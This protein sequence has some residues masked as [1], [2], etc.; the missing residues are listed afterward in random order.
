MAQEYGWIAAILRTIL[1][2]IDWTI[3]SG[4]RLV[5][6]GIFDLANLTTSSG[7]MGD[8]YSRIY[9][10]L[11]V[12]MAFKL[13]F[14]FFQYIV[15]PDSMTGKS[16]T[17]VGKLISRAI[18][19][20]IA[21]VALPGILFGKG[22]QPGLL[23]RAQ[24]AILP[25]LPRII[26]GS[27]GS[28]ITS[29]DTGVGANSE[30]DNAIDIASKTMAVQ[31]MRAFMSP[32]INIEEVCKN[33]KYDDIPELQSLDD[34][35]KNSQLTCN[36]KEGLFAKYYVYNYSYFFPT[37]T[38]II[39]LIMLLGITIDV[40]K[41]V[42]KM[43]IL[44]AIAPIPIMSLIDPKSSKDGGFNKWVKML[45]STFLSIFLEL[46]VVY[47]VLMLIQRIVSNKGLFD[48]FPS[49][50]TPEGFFRGSYLTVFLILGLLLFA[51]EAPKFIKDAFGLKDDGSS[52]AGFGAGL[53]AMAGLAT[54]RSLSG[55]AQG[56]AAGLT[57][58]PKVGA[59]T[60]GRDKAGQIKH[61]DPNWKGDLGAKL[62]R[63]SGNRAAAKYGLNEES[64]T[65]ADDHA[66]A[67]ESTALSAKA[68][69]EEK[70]HRGGTD[71][72]LADLRKKSNDAQEAATF[73][74]KNH[75]KAVKDRQ[76]LGASSTSGVDKR[77][78]ARQGKGYIA[79][80]VNEG[81]TK[82]GAKVGLERYGGSSTDRKDG[83]EK[84]EAMVEAS[85][86]LENIS[87]ARKAQE[88]GNFNPYAV[89]SKGK[90]ADPKNLTSEPPDKAALKADYETKK[91]DYKNNPNKKW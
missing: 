41:R 51:K 85:D 31:T 27:S 66:K 28:G 32:A 91:D 82:I 59:W 87:A 62:S 24:T 86:R 3:F 78:A 43:I 71:A 58:D 7:I 9:V 23:N 90:M 54:G 80:H 4:I 79:R 55:M 65:R 47:I 44:E 38:G 35:L 5:L 81:A 57:A 63:F 77:R 83:L 6:F 10:L 13:S 25:M 48:N 60:A 49:F 40:A 33:V 26:F 76:A 39:M 72:E 88:R 46:G 1:S 17:G 21:L 50:S 61:G 67:L 30:K 73:A 42:F 52:W 14:S 29:T 34:V 11:G 20:I 75:E 68:D 36:S 2:T 8:I 12:F 19:M 89:T 18:V 69:Y 70:L 74:R 15:S 53:G 84:R 56:A 16:E 22:G 64:I 45:T 37:I